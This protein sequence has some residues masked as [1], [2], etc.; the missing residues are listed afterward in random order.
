MLTLRNPL[1]VAPTETAGV[2]TAALFGAPPQAASKPSP[3]RAAA[4]S[5]VP[6]APVVPVAMPWKV[7]TIR[8]GKSELDTLED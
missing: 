7:E 6:E 1:D 2:S 3:R 5:P 8:A 4:P